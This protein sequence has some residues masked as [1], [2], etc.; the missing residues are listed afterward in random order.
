MV[1]YEIDAD[2]HI[3]E[4]YDALRI[5]EGEGAGERGIRIIV[6]G[7]KWIGKSEI[8]RKAAEESGGVYCRSLRDVERA[9]N[10]GKVPYIDDLYYLIWE[11]LVGE[12]Q[13]RSV[14]KGSGAELLLEALKGEHVVA[15]S[16]Y[17]LEWILN[18][19]KELEVEG[20]EGWGLQLSELLLKDKVILPRYEREHVEGMHGI[21]RFSIGGLSVRRDVSVGEVRGIHKVSFW[22]R[23]GK[24]SIKYESVVPKSL[25]SDAIGWSVREPSNKVKRLLNITKGLL[26]SLS[27]AMDLIPKI[28]AVLGMSVP[29]I[30]N[31]IAGLFLAI[32]LNLGGLWSSSAISDLMGVPPH[33]REELEKENGVL[34]GTYTYQEGIRD[35]IGRSIGKLGKVI[36]EVRDLL[37]LERGDLSEV[38]KKLDS[39]RRELEEEL[40]RM[41]ER[42]LR[43]EVSFFWR[44]G[45]FGYATLEDLG[46]YLYGVGPQGERVY[47]GFVDMLKCPEYVRLVEEVVRKADRDVVFVVGPSGS[48]KTS[49]LYFTARY[50]SEGGRLFSYVL[51]DRIRRRGLDS[52]HAEEGIYLFLNDPSYEEF[53]AVM[54]ADE[55]RRRRVIVAVREMVLAEYVRRYVDE[56]RMEL[57]RPFAITE[58]ELLG[59]IYGNSVTVEYEEARKYLEHLIMGLFGEADPEAL[60]IVIEKARSQWYG[61]GRERVSPSLYYVKLLHEDLTARG[62]KLSREVAGGIP[63]DL[64]DLE[65][66]FLVRLYGGEVPKGRGLTRDERRRLLR[67]A[68]VLIPLAALGINGRLHRLVF[69]G[70]QEETVRWL[71]RVGWVDEGELEDFQRNVSMYISYKGGEFI[72]FP[73]DSWEILLDTTPLNE[74]YGRYARGTWVER[75]ESL[76]GS[77]ADILMEEVPEE[78]RIVEWGSARVKFTVLVNA[79][80][81]EAARG[82][83]REFLDGLTGKWYREVGLFHYERSSSREVRIS[84]FHVCELIERGEVR[85]DYLTCKEFWDWAFEDVKG[86]IGAAREG[87]EA[88]ARALEY[89]S[90]IEGL[91]EIVKEVMDSLEK[92][93]E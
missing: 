74:E 23:R 15:V 63:D 4:P 16:I 61:G 62:V 60:D 82:R 12:K 71:G 39:I 34:P 58:E 26:E 27:S 36:G 11:V 42:L 89:L 46:D 72:G 21:L 55:V 2:A 35:L 68:S 83:R 78:Y 65:A 45:I 9:L 22:I 57:E 87:N 80:T 54:E 32:S 93:G 77:I 43:E 50:L 51:E 75:L 40:R 66:Q 41:E 18:R 13:R 69:D 7:P 24:D 6:S 8:L 5:A 86:L 76:M 30:L 37:E 25:L 49:L 59:R 81:L 64:L 88:A 91:A 17:E 33:L 90:E 19:L 67:V 84:V 3:V 48:G 85:R 31:P 53:R 1:V 73:H 47:E 92:S 38:V 56:R 20:Y 29:G 44:R 10:D 52:F 70:V 79:I 28:G 14:G